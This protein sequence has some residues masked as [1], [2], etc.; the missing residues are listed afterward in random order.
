MLKFFNSDKLGLCKVGYKDVMEAV[1]TGVDKWARP[2]KDKFAM[3]ERLD[4]DKD[5]ELTA[6]EALALQAIINIE[7]H[8]PGGVKTWGP[9]DKPPAK[10]GIHG[11]ATPMR[12]SLD[13]MLMDLHIRNVVVLKECMERNGKPVCIGFLEMVST[14]G[15]TP[16]SG[17]AESFWNTATADG[18]DD[19]HVHQHQHQHQQGGGRGPPS[20]G[21][22]MSRL[23]STSSPPRSLSNPNN[24]RD[25]LH[26]EASPAAQSLL[27]RG[28]SLLA[29]ELSSPPSKSRV[30]GLSASLSSKLRKT[31]I[32]PFMTSA[33]EERDK[34]P[35]L[36]QS[37]KAR[38]LDI[39]K[40]AWS[41]ASNPNTAES[42]PSIDT[43]P[44]EKRPRSRAGETPS[45]GLMSRQSVAHQSLGRQSSSP[46]G[47]RQEQS[48]P[49]LGGRHTA[50]GASILS[51][52][53]VSPSM[54]RTGLSGEAL[55]NYEDSMMASRLFRGASPG[56]PWTGNMERTE[57]EIC[58][59]PSPKSLLPLP[60][61][62]PP[63]LHPSLPQPLEPQ[64]PL[65]V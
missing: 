29:G 46:S 32:V 13:K 64:T 31:D 63:S 26:D 23:E 51:R 17:Q 3:C 40:Q 21:S 33:T 25:S 10:A 60:P 65:E 48:S 14:I 2:D 24:P 8:T 1:V 15:A 44:Q 39:A 36:M 47:P 34:S 7:V 52:T 37:R 53:S 12:R 54:A 28:A 4:S 62:L 41:H 58:G 16:L 57:L 56:P 18:Y 35:I 55:S 19:A 20:E 49:G 9:V 22:S 43:S 61:S 45:D 30:G 59:R 11:D 5:G 6:L 50:S 38:A 42:L 27:S